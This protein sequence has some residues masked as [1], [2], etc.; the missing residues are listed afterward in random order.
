VFTAILLCIVAAVTE[1]ATTKI[2][3]EA[4]NVSMSTRGALGRNLRNAEVIESMG[5][6]D[7]IRQRWMVGAIKVLELQSVASSRAG[8]LTALSKIIRLSS[9]SLILGLGAYLVIERWRQLILL[10]AP[11]KVLLAPAAN[12]IVLTTCSGKFQPIKN[13]CCCLILKV[14]F[15]WKMPWLF[16]RAANCRCS[17]A[18]IW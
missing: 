6:L 15:S 10:S 9:Q 8:L 13:A 7:K 5:M 1:K 4:N 14:V 17:K 16:R 18:S 12:I 2:L 3:S 11:G